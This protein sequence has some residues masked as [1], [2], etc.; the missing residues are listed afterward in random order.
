MILATSVALIF[1]GYFNLVA[2]M[3]SLVILTNK[4][5]VRKSSILVVDMGICLI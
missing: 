4:H 3:F 1:L 2:Y 5:L